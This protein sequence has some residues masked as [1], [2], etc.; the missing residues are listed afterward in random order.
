MIEFDEF[1][2]E[3]IL[4]VYNPEIGMKGFVVIDNTAL[5]PGKGGIRMTPTVTP[6]E[7]YKLARVMSWKNALAELPFGGAKSGIVADPKTM[8]N[9]H[10]QKIVAA[11]GEAL[12][13]VS[14]D[15]Y[16][17]APD[18]NMGEGEV[19]SYVEANGSDK[20]ATGK[21]LS[22][23][24]LPHELGSTGF[25]VFHATKVAAEHLGKELGELTF[26]V[27]GFGNVGSFASKFLT[28]AGAK[29]TH[30]S[31]SKGEVCLPEG[32]EFSKISDVKQKT[33]SVVNYEHTEKHFCE[34]LAAEEAD[35]L[36]TAAIPDFINSSNV[37]KVKAKIVV[38]GSNI[39]MTI[40][41]EEIL[42]KKGVLIVPDAVANAGGVIS[43][44]VEHIGGSQEEMFKMIEEKITRNT[45]LVL[46]KA[47]EEK[48]LPREAAVEIAKERILE[49]TK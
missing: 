38:Q 9:E 15:L 10:K 44:Y 23:K 6:V 1:G 13:P 21:P 8:G 35:V 37:N 45:K 46:E 3:K 20:S 31:D 30:V 48:K 28:E 2:P 42:A 12:R 22:M 14:P 47:A 33:G 11:F 25:G 17:A 49:K 4:E 32:F 41:V 24:G 18:I 29:M 40:G 16:I 7:V 39:P 5:G 43:S 34:D 26:A 27:E 36:I 19:K